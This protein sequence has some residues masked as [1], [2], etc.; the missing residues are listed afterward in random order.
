LLAEENRCQLKKSRACA[1]DRETARRDVGARRD[2]MACTVRD[3]LPE[4][5]RLFNQTQR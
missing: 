1:A 3:E 5:Y 4:K 2:I